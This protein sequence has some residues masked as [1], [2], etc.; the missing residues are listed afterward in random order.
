[1][2]A[3]QQAQKLLSGQLESA[4]RQYVTATS[5]PGSS[6]TDREKRGK[7][8]DSALPP[9][10]LRFYG[11]GAM[12]ATGGGAPTTS[13]GGAPAGPAV[14][15]VQD[16]YRFKGGDPGKQESWEKVQTRQQ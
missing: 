6:E 3:V 7:H 8:F 9:A 2:G 11:R 14:G 5:M 4:R 15:T 1:M 10:A 16:G 13:G 12:P